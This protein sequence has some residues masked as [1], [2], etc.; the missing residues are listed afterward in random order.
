MALIHIPV[1]PPVRGV[2]LDPPAEQIPLDGAATLK[3]IFVRGGRAISRDGI[4]DFLTNASAQRVISLFNLQFATGLVEVLRADQDTVYRYDT[5]AAPA[6]TA[7]TGV[8]WAGTENDPFW[9]VRA[10]WGSEVKGR[11]IVGNGYANIPQSW[12]GAAGTF[13]TVTNAFPAKY[14]V[15]GP[16]NRLFLANVKDG[17]D[18]L[19]QDIQWSQ[20]LLPAGAGTDWT[21]TGS[22]RLSLRNDSWPI[23]A[24]WVQ[25]GRIFIG[26]TRSISV[27]NPTG[28]ARN[29]YGYSVLS[30]DGDG[31]LAGPSLVQFGNFSAFL[32][33]SGFQAFDSASLTPLA[34]QNR[35]ELQDRLNFSAFSR[36]TGVVDRVRGRVGWGLPL[37]GSD[38]PTEIWWY[39]IRNRSW[40]IDPMPHSAIARF[41]AVDQT[42]I[43]E[44]NPSPS[45]YINNFAGTVEIDELSDIATEKPEILI[46][47]NNGSTKKLTFGESQDLGQM[48]QCEYVS[49]AIPTLQQTQKIGGTD[50]PLTLD[51]H[52]VIDAVEVSLIDRGSTYTVEVAVTEDGGATFIVLGNITL[53]TSQPES[54]G[55][56]KLER[57]SKRISVRDRL[58]I[59][60]KNT[61]DNTPWGWTGLI[62]RYDTVGRRL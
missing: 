31:V 46:G 19:T 45:G 61:T 21:G 18:N 16:D 26:K 37:D 24:I 51:S 43:D 52:I 9:A 12:A 1:P 33:E 35:D 32:S 48:I 53:T 42:F 41:S 13:S 4:V 8:T 58:Q 38:T 47:R 28:V 6:W 50:R 14:A 5:T 17:S 36:V 59:R 44:L 55:R 60:L 40:E 30:T 34:Q 3:N 23:T 20:V 57:V 25:A 22:G 49:G 29:A 54:A 7:I 56:L 39:N 10:P 27:L 11:I 62:V 15:V 2:Y